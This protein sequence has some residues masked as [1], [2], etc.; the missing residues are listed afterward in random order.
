MDPNICKIEK[1]LD[2]VFKES[3]GQVSQYDYYNIIRI[4]TM[5]ILPEYK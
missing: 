3:G 2:V 4:H 5:T 1:K